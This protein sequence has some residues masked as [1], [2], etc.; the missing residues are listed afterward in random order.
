LEID[1]SA[2]PNL[3][4]WTDEISKRAAVTKGL[5]VPSTG[6][7]EEERN[8]FFKSARARIDGMTNSD[9]Q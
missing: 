6:K 8:A 4:K 1:L 2:F 3:K 9:K 7:T 5:D